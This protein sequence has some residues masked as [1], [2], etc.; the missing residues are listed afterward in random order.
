MISG[1]VGLAAGNAERASHRG[2]GGRDDKRHES[3]PEEVPAFAGHGGKDDEVAGGESQSGGRLGEVFRSQGFLYLVGF[4]ED[5]KGEDA[6]RLQPVPQ[7]EVV[8]GGGVA[9]I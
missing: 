3:V 1:W 4:G 8:W 5:R 2:F 9:K 7:G 6:G